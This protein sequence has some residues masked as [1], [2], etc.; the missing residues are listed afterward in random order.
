MKTGLVL[1][2]GAMRGMYTAGVL[3][4]MMENNIDIDGIVGVSA[5]AVFGCNYKSRQ[6]GRAIRYN[7]TY[8]NDPRYISFRS[9]IKTGDLY[10]EQF[11]YHEVPDVLDP[12]DT[13]TFAANPIDFYIVCTDVHT[14]KPV[15]QLCNKGDAEDIQW[16]RAS[17][18]M[19]LVSRVVSVA[20]HDMLDGGIVDP[21][22]LSWF[23]SIG[24]EKN[25]VIL[26]RPEGYRK[27]KSNSVPLVRLSLRKYPAV[28]AA[29]KKRHEVYNSTLDELYSL[30]EDENTFVL[31]PSKTIK[32]SRTEKDPEV[33]KA[34]YQLGRQDAMKNLDAM[35][36]FINK[37]AVV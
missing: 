8:C 1:E 23:R 4:V 28:A 18:S 25:I 7:T 26:T 35:S 30:K 27:K 3:D 36:K 37:Q 24:Y 2:G 32:I 20:G 22:P 21:I 17:A 6:I 33:L 15:Y 31:Q 9:L 13:E 19:P 12:F 16:M 34:M 14:G 5:G 29:M 10:N 11:C